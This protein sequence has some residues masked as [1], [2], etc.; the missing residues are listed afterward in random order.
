[1][2]IRI[3]IRIRTQDFSDQKPVQFYSWQKILFLKISSCNFLTHGLHEGCPSYGRILQ[4]SKEN[5]QHL[6]HETSHFYQFVI[7]AKNQCGSGS[8]TLLLCKLNFKSI[9]YS[10]HYA[11]SSGYTKAIVC[12]VILFKQTTLFQFYRHFTTRMVFAG[13]VDLLRVRLF[14]DSLYGIV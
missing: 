7:F 2:S 1:M 9:P 10:Y 13:N 5:I 8:T 12:S 6:K 4:P 14:I 11:C 3:R